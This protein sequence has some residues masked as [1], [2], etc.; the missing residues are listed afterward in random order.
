MYVLQA[1]WIQSETIRR[2]NWKSSK[3][4]ALR[5]L[6]LT[7]RLSIYWVFHDLLVCSELPY[8]E[9]MDPKKGW[10]CVKTTTLHLRL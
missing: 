2:T 3:F 9:I 1:V 4:K 6:S 8:C 7:I 10:G 5:E